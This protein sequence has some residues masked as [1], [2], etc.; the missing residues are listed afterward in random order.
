[1]VHVAC[2]LDESIDAPMGLQ[3]VM[4]ES[5]SGLCR[6]EYWDTHVL[7]FVLAEPGEQVQLVFYVAAVESDSAGGIRLTGVDPRGLPAITQPFSSLTEHDAGVLVEGIGTVRRLARTKALRW[8]TGAELDPG[9]GVDL[10]TYA[11]A[12]TAGY[13][14]PVGTCR[15]GRSDDDRAVVDPTGRVFGTTN[16]VVAD[17]S[18]FPTIPRAN[19]SLPTIGV[20]EFIASTIP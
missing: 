19:T 20:A 3:S 13:W 11:R 1:M 7:L 9:P 6:D 4:L 16:L 10:E 5:R 2:A 18:I 17:A 8:A 12:A 15:M 14:H